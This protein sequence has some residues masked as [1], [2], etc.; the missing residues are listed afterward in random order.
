MKY[1]S[2]LLLGL[3]SGVSLRAALPMEVTVTQPTSFEIM[4]DGRA[5]GSFSL[6]P[7]TKLEVIDVEDDYLLVR[8]RNANGRVHIGHTDL[9]PGAMADETKPAVPAKPTK[10]AGAAVKAA[11]VSSVPAN[12]MERALGKKLVHYDGGI[13]RSFDGAR[14]AGVKFYALYFSASWCPPCRA[15]TPR[16]IEAYAQIRAQY[17][18]FELVLVNRDESEQAMLEYMRGD[19]MKWPAVGWNA[20]RGVPEIDRYAGDG[21]PDLVLVDENGQVLSDSYRNGGY[22]GPGVV[23]NDTVKILRDYRSQ[24]PRS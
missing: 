18:E 16:L 23:L 1:F 3:L 4:R 9:P 7:G 12:A 6:A 2:L 19:A 22:V 21:I 15:F 17:P 11:G 13:M 14:L 5:S 8:Y 24:H 10:K 20:L